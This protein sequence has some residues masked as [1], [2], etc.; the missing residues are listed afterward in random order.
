M[1]GE[2]LGPALAFAKYQT[3][4]RSLLQPNPG[5]NDDAKAAFM[6]RNWLTEHVRDGRWAEVRRLEHAI[7]AERLGPGMFKRA[8]Q[9]MEFN[10]AIEIG[11]AGRKKVVRI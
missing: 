2:M 1:T 11:K 9:S 10:Q 3:R 7:H 6:I 8:L 4:V 5:Q